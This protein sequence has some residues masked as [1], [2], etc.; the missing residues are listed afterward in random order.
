M[1]EQQI[2]LLIL[3]FLNDNV[4]HVFVDDRQKIFAAKSK[5]NRADTK[6]QGPV[7]WNTHNNFIMGMRTYTHN[8]NKLH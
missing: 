5:Q 8:L 6:G 3:P 4:K 2:S 7:A 1:Q